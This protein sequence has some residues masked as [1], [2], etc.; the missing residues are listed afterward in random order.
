MIGAL[1]GMALP[2]LKAAKWIGLALGAAAILGTIGYLYARGEV[3]QARADR[4]E[5]DVKIER[6]NTAIE[7]ASAEANLEVAQ[8][9]LADIERERQL[10]TTLKRDLAAKPRIVERI[11]EITRDLPPAS[12]PAPPRIAAFFDE[13][14]G[15][16]GSGQGSGA[17]DPAGKAA[18]PA[19]PARIPV[20][21]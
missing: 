9:L 7:R 17:V 16:P 2:H 14:R 10:V 6:Q 13:L 21:R 4:L 1:I 8:T 20:P 12:C 11:K 3:R 19:G 18:H 5:R 15:D